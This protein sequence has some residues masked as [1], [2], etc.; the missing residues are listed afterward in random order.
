MSLCFISIE[1][2]SDA[3]DEM[4]NG[5]THIQAEVQVDDHDEMYQDA[6]I[7]GQ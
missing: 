2:L 6:G 5:K 4:F 3:M 7:M 1:W